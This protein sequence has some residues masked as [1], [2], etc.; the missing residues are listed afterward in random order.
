MR[1][2][3]ILNKDFKMQSKI[4]KFENRARAKTKR[5]S[6]H[7]Y[8]LTLQDL[9]AAE[10]F[11]V[12]MTQ[13]WCRTSIQKMDPLPLM[14]ESV[15]EIL[16]TDDQEGFVQYVNYILYLFLNVSSY[17]LT[18][19]CQ[20]CKKIGSFELNLMA[21]IS[22]QQSREDSL[23]KN[24]LGHILGV[25]YSED[26]KYYIQSISNIYLENNLKLILRPE[27]QDLF[28]LR[29]PLMAQLP[30]MQQRLN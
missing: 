12:W 20:H 18:L 9:N 4:I 24:L 3:L 15:T 25:N 29:S 23:T 28:Q 5:H 22:F 27:Y 14:R 8:H 30:K 26:T 1:L 2:I 21:L 17:P 10:N 19:G 11:L 6:K 7:T 13:Y 16:G